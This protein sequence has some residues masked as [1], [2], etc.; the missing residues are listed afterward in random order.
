[1]W[2]TRTAILFACLLYLNMGTALVHANGDSS[3]DPVLLSVKSRDFPVVLEEVAKLDRRGRGSDLALVQLLD[4]YIGEGPQV[5]LEEAIT[6]RGKRMLALL[7]KA[8]QQGPNCAAAYQQQCLTADKNGNRLRS[9]R[10]ARL[11]N[12]IKAGVVLCSELDK[13][14]RV[15]Q[16]P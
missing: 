8:R 9:A 1:M 14:P 16:S 15:D 12:A 13:C 5:L 7:A 2:T 6:R 3:L 10:V 4:Y 11:S